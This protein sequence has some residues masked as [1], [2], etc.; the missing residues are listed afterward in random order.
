MARAARASAVDGRQSTTFL[1][2]GIGVAEFV[3]RSLWNRQTRSLSHV[4]ARGKGSG[5]GFAEDYAALVS[6]LI[7]LYDATFA[8][9]WL[10]FA[11]E[12]QRAMDADFWDEIGGG[13]FRS[14]ASD[15]SVYL[16]LKDCFD[17]NDASANSQ[18]ALNLFRLGAILNDFSFRERGF[19]VLQA[20]RELWEKTPWNHA[21]LLLSLEWALTPPKRVLLWGRVS[22]EGEDA[23]ADELGDRR[24][25]PFV[26]IRADLLVNDDSP[27]IAGV[28]PSGIPQG[29]TGEFHV[30]RDETLLGIA[31]T[32]AELRDLLTFGSE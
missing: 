17:S 13:Y 20:F 7:E 15:A 19:Q 1:D 29:K 26:S 28:V 27:E 9:R 2:A 16:R 3:E 4:Y 6:G 11:V 10:K 8:P 25:G 5:V 12:V 30:Y 31:Q 24:R 32:A 22:D 18:A 14:A 21:H 23:L